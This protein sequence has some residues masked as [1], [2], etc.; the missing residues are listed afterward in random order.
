MRHVVFVGGTSYSGSTLLDMM[1]SHD[2][3]GF[4]CGELSSF[5]YPYRTKHLAP[6]CACGD[7][8]CDL[9]QRLDHRPKHV[10]EALFAEFPDKLIHVDS[11][12]SPL[13]I[14]E[15]SRLLTRRGVTVSNVLIWKTPAEF[16]ASRRKRGLE[17][18]WADD[19]IQYHRR[20]FTLV[21]RW[22]SVPYDVLVTEPGSLAELCGRL[23]LSYFE[24]KHRYWEQTHH[25][26]F[27][28]ASARIHLYETNS[29]PYR[30][31]AEELPR[32]GNGAAHRSIYRQP[33]PCDTPRLPDSRQRRMDEIV[34]V[35]S[36]TD[37]RNATDWSA[38]RP[39]RKALAVPRVTFPLQRL[40]R[41]ARSW[42]TKR[43]DR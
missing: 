17:Q 34:E 11:S 6:D 9:W 24:G 43:A 37:L 5:V 1:L 38:L 31:N 18:G 32:T 42:R 21:D 19:W 27:G 39:R 20:Y 33:P 14:E 13:W 15:Q 22:V 40:V 8:A 28:N 30:S 10:H 35:L 3:A 36:A 2:P 12:K 23:G 7:S 26:L 29:T 4:S 25:T 41:S 16:L